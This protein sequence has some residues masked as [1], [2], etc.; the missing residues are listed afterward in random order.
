MRRAFGVPVLYVT[1]NVDEVVRLAN[2][3]LLLSAGRVGAYGKVAEVLGRLDL[4]PLTGG[5]ETAL[6]GFFFFYVSCVAITWFYYTRRGGLLRDVERGGTLP[7][8]VTQPA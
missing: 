7:P 1:H 3:M 5:V 4:S 8:T 2:D 6:W